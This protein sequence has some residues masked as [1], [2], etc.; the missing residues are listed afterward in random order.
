MLRS[1][2]TGVGGVKGHQVMLD[3]VGNNISNVNTVGFKRS[4]VNFQDLLYQTSRGASAPSGNRGGVNALQVG[5]G[6]KVAAVETVHTQGA[7]QS[8]GNPL[9][10]AIQGDG[11]F[12]VRGGGNTYYTRAGNFVMDG[13]GNVVQAG[14]GYYLQGYQ[15]TVDAATGEE[16]I[17]TTLSD[18]LIPVGSKLE[19]KATRNVWYK[20]N[21]DSRVSSFVPMGFDERDVEVRYGLSLSGL[22][23]T[24]VTVRFQE[25][26]QD[27]ATE[28]FLRMELLLP[29][30]N[31]PLPIRIF[32]AGVEPDRGKVL[33]AISSIHTAVNVLTTGALRVDMDRDGSFDFTVQVRDGG[34]LTFESLYSVVSARQIHRFDLSDL[35]DF[36]MRSFAAN[37]AGLQLGYLFDF[38]FHPQ[39]G[40]NMLLKVI[41]INSP[42][43]AAPFYYQV[44][45][46]LMNPDG[47]FREI[48]MPSSFSSLRAFSAS[49]ISLDPLGRS[50][51]FRSFYDRTQSLSISQRP[52]SM[53]SSKIE[54]YDSQ[55]NPYTLETI[56]R[57]VDNNRWEWRVYMPD[58]PSVP[59]SGNFGFVEFGPDGLIRSGNP[60]D[61]LRIFP[62]GAE[63]LSVNLDFDGV[64]SRTE[65]VTQFGSDFSTKAYMQDGY[66]MGVLQSFNVSQ[67]GSVVGVYSNGRSKV[68]YR[69]PLATFNNPS[70]LLKVGDTVFAASTNSGEPVLNLA[71]TGGTGSIL[72]GN[73]EMSNVDLTEEFVRL[74]MAQRGFQASARVITTSDQVL[75]ELMNIKR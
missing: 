75:E 4:V 21:L 17:S 54:V 73:L 68:L 2:F 44:F 34:V 70:G 55:G 27:I 8:T 71:Q 57:K 53:T 74:I 22:G 36:G 42:G 41:Q 3:V 23:S 69:I 56:F 16:V 63:V 31:S 60:T 45:T 12:A 13:A 35:D 49:T 7:I 25:V 6:V 38:D 10:M 32:P 37:S 1:M 65:G 40:G 46:V 19:A 30:S 20:C 47:T 50:I 33:Y 48:L 59:M 24:E 28:G 11:Y 67:D 9:D 66:P 18:V 39:G 58:D 52:S 61:P 43:A 62:P 64:N 15:V 14:T 51:T 29:G 72:G 5:L 26:E